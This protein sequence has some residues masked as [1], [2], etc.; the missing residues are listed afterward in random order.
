MLSGVSD[1]GRKAI[2]MTS[3]R[4]E[5]IRVQRAGSNEQGV[6]DSTRDCSNL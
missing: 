5:T 3:A 4:A 1:G 6:D 2:D